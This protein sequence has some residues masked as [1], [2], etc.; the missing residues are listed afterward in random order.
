MDGYMK[1]VIFMEKTSRI[2]RCIM[3]SLVAIAIVVSLFIA[4]AYTNKYSSLVSVYFDAE[5]Q[6]IINEE[7]EDSNY[8]KSDYANEAELKEHLSQ[9]GSQ[10]EEEGAVLLENNGTLP[11][12]KNLKIT[13]LGQDCADLVYGGGGAGSVATEKAIDLYTALEEAGYTVNPVAKDFYANGNGASYRKTVI[14]AYGQGEFAVNEVP[15]SEYTDD[16]KSSFADYNDAAIVLIGRSGGESA[17][18]TTGTL[19]SGSKYLE[20]DSNEL[21]LIKLATDNFDKVVVLLNTQNPLELGALSDMEVDA[22][23]WIGALGENGTYGLAALLDGDAS[24]SGRLVDTYAYDSMSAPA[25][26]NFGSYT[27]AGSEEAFG[28][29]Y[30][31]YA[32]GI[33]VGYRYYETRYEDVVLG[34]ESAENFDYKTTVQY[35]FG[36]GL[37]YTAFEYSNY[38]VNET[39]STYEVSVDVKNVG[40]VPSKEVVQVYMQSPY[41][42]YDRE[43]FIEK[44]SVELVGYEKTDVIS[45]GEAQTVTVS[46]PK[47]SMKTY[48]QYGYGTYIVDAGD[49]YFAVGK[50]SHDAL[51]NILALKGYNESNGMDYAGDASL[52]AAFNVAEL[53]ATTYAQSISTGNVVANQFEDVDIKYYDNEFKYLSRADWTGTWPATYADGNWNAPKELIDGEAIITVEDTVKD[54]PVTGQISDEYGKLNVAMLRDVDYSDPLWDVLIQQMSVEELDNLVRVGGY[55]T[56]AVDSIQLPATVDKD[57]TAGISSTL[58]GGEN[59]MAYPPEIVLASTWNKELAEEFG[60][61]IGEDSI[62]LK[63][64]GWYAPA[65]NIHR[66]PYSGRN[67]EY[68]SEDGFLSGAM[69][70][71][72]VSGAQS[73][74]AM[75]TIKHFAL[76]D[77]ETNRMGVNIFAGEQAIR[78]IYLKAF[79]A[80]VTEADAHGVM[81]SMNRIGNTWTGGHVGLM[82]NVLRNEWG[83]NGFVITDQASYNVFAYEDLREGLAAGTSLWLNSDSEL[84]KLADEDMTNT[85]ISN[86]QRA[87]KDI[88]FAIS[89]SN[90]MNGLSAG[91]KIVQITPWWKIA[92][93]ALFVIMAVIAFIPIVLSILDLVNGD[94]KK[95]RRT[96][97]IIDIVFSILLFG[98]GLSLILL[99]SND[100][101]LSAE[102][103]PIGIAIGSIGLV[104]T[105]LLIII[106]RIYKEKNPE[107]TVE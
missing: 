15:V 75:V 90:A 107:I 80:A 100:A 97:F 57:G 24:F 23:A 70:A 20:L 29:N 106:S 55:G 1:E 73:K 67:F 18:L 27:I 30:M 105:A 52:A 43:N 87:A 50:N 51:N 34:N 8:F 85:V 94:S 19:P 36:Y 9:V 81:A 48:D 93:Y 86:M 41:T 6:K 88:V 54:T 53:D 79:E 71:A 59:G 69:G 14:D 68:Y 64:A 95:R 91:A 74:G 72:T 102:F 62:A 16:I 11:L 82:T 92:L 7:G 76:N 35:P 42:D 56:A 26:A 3:A 44:S 66:T 60:R 84:W 89:R 96:S 33:Y 65:M 83:F 77:Q 63:V 2:L 21:D 99:T 31:V 78:E 28:T 32:E 101:D 13:L 98:A 104:L 4:N 37:S 10:I 47:E 25:M 39:D 12:E 46:V 103:M 17:D 40:D 61:C 49:Y 22:V 38:T 5:T 45:A 58:V